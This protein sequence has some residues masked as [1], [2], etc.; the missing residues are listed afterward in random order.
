MIPDYDMKG[1]T[2]S[3]FIPL[4]GFQ[5]NR[6]VTSELLNLRVSFYWFKFADEKLLSTFRNWTSS[7]T[8]PDFIVMGL[9]QFNNKC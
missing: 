5:Q 4:K 7:R 9:H 2:K 3:T 1:K 8:P 6:Q